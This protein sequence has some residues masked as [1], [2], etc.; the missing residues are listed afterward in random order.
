MTHHDSPEL[1]IGHGWSWFCNVWHRLCDPH[2]FANTLSTGHCQSDTFLLTHFSNIHNIILMVPMNSVHFIDKMS[3][4]QLYASYHNMTNPD[5]HD[6]CDFS[7]PYARQCK[8]VDFLS[9]GQCQTCSILLEESVLSEGDW[10]PCKTA[11]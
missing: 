1:S 11:Q 7:L 9:S 2:L 10:L 8:I 5:L 6:F 4:V 3:M